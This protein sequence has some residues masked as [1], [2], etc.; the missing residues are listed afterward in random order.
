MKIIN[1]DRKRDVSSLFL[2]LME[3]EITNEEF[4]KL[5]GLEPATNNPSRKAWEV[6]NK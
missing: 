3:N 4:E 6:R 2:R 5:T 1:T